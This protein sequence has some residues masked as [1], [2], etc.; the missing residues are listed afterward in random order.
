MTPLELS[1]SGDTFW[2]TTLKAKAKAVTHCG[3]GDT[4]DRHLRL[5]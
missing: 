5:S 4:H 2:S 1:V 3:T